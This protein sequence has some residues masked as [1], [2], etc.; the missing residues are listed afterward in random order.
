MEERPRFWT[1]YKL[2]FTV[3]GSC[4]DGTI[5]KYIETT[6]NAET[7]GLVLKRLFPT[8]QQNSRPTINLE[9]MM[10]RRDLY[11]D[12]SQPV[13]LLLCLCHVMIF[14]K[15]AYIDAELT[16]ESDGLDWKTPSSTSLIY[17]PAKYCQE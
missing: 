5:H 9:R 2:F 11:L 14:W 4:S 10:L 6:F 8:G 15:S 17:R 12:T 13:I 16:A 7:D 1:N 3:F